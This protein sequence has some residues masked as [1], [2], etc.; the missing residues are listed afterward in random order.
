LNQDR[1]KFIALTAVTV[2][3]AENEFSV[4][5]MALNSSELLAIQEIEVE[6]TA[7]VALAG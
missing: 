6:E 1:H 4:P 2:R 3:S 7:D 5:F